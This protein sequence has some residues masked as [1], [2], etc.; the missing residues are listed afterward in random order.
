MAGY[1]L[2]TFDGDVFRQLTTSPTDGQAAILARYIV[3]RVGEADGW[4][5]DLG[6]LTAAIRKRLAAADWYAGLSDDD[7]RLWDD[8]VF[9]LCREPGEA[10]GIDFRCSD[11][12]SIYWDCA[13]E[14]ASQ[15]ADLMSEPRFGA[16]GYRFF[17]EPSHDY[18]YHRAYSIFDPEGV[19]ALLRQLLAGEP[20]FAEFP[21][22]EDDE[23]S[24]RE[25]FFQGLLPVVRFAAE[26]GRTLFVQT[27]T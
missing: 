3:E 14:A 24:L 4:P 1:F 25:Q 5:A 12:E 23:G 17:G 20:H 18:G 19:R 7:A 9:S 2:Y 26:N 15:G 21:E 11:Y 6:D 13:E 8:I 27:D 22:D 16:S 10:I